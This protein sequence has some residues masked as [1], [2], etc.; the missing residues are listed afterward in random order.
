MQ[1]LFVFSVMSANELNNEQ[2]KKLVRKGANFSKIC[3]DNALVIYLDFTSKHKAKINSIVKQ[4]IEK[5]KF[6][7][8]YAKQTRV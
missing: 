4:N 7:L 1:G 2:V 6:F 8:R 5:T 3:F